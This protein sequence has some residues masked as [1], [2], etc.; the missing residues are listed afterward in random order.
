MFAAKPAHSED[1]IGPE[2][3]TEDVFKELD[4]LFQPVGESRTLPKRIK[5][6]FVHNTCPLKR[7]TKTLT[8]LISSFSFFTNCLTVSWS[9]STSSPKPVSWQLKGSSSLI[10]CLACQLQSRVFHH[11]RSTWFINWPGYQKVFC[12]VPTLLPQRRCLGWQREYL[13]QRQSIGCHQS[14]PRP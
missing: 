8:C 3:G 10:S 12:L 6:G 2:A 4:H 1:D 5:T 11:P 7:M 14:F 9:L 13:P